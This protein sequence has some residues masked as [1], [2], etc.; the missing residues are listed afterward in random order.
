SEGGRVTAAA[1]LTTNG[2]V[3]ALGDLTF[4]TEPYSAAENNGMLINNIADFL[5]GGQPEFKITDFPVFFRNEIDIVFDN[6]LVFNSQF[7]DAAKLKD[8]LE[9]Q[10][11]TVNFV[12]EIGT[13][14]DVI[15]I[16]RYDNT[17]AID[18]ILA[19]G[20]ISILDPIND[21]LDSTTEEAVPTEEPA[22]SETTDK[23]ASTKVNNT[24][25]GDGIEDRFIEGRVKIKGIGDLERGGSTLFYL[26]QD[27]ERNIL[28]VLSDNAD[29]NADAFDIL[30][31][32]KLLECQASPQIAVCQTEKPDEELP[33]SLRSS[34]ID[35]ILVVS[36]D[37]GR[38]RADGQ[39][40]VLDYTDAFSQTSYKVDTWETTEQGSPDLDTLLEYDALIWTTGDY[41]D[42]SIG[43]EDVQLLTEY[44]GVGG[45]LIMSGA[46]IAFDWDHTDFVTNIAHADYLNFSQVSSIEVAL[47]DH[48]ISRDFEDISVIEFLETPSEEE[49]LTDVVNHTPNSR[50]I[51]RRAPGGDDEGAPA[52]IAYEDDRSKIAYYVFPLYLMPPAERTLLVNN[53]VD[54]FTKKVL[55]LPDE[56]DYVPFESDIVKD[57]TGNDETT[58]D[59][60]TGDNSDSGG[61]DGSGTDE[62]NNN[63]GGGN[64]GGNDG[65]GNDG[66][67]NDGG[68]DGGGNDGGG[69]GS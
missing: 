24:A 17:E 27:G 55:D 59:E 60:T 67:G 5:T 48:T 22:D 69:N 15:F 37:G 53:T 46:S 3:L 65:G 14:N 16:G 19:A 50:V 18:S 34:R 10:K 23:A 42:D 61:D 20:N 2:Q 28:V 4:F 43:Q 32:N 29:T 6:P 25:T 12:N 33:P 13:E 36:D 26:H 41:W 66:G 57:D 1:A 51:F 8:F 40:S 39:T 7:D 49:L 21:P 47:D 30:I 35:K 56:K 11:H 9:Q 31:D 62:G 52:V 64:D 63:D 38:K 54:W 68:N 45:N 44:V 58:G